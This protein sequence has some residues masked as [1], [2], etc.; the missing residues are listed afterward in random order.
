[1][2]KIREGVGK[3]VDEDRGGVGGGVRNGGGG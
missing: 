1:V 2:W 3:G